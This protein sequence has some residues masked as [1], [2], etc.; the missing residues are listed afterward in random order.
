MLVEGKEIRSA[1]ELVALIEAQIASGRLRPNDRL[2]PVRAVADELGLA[3]NTV[4]AAYRTL[5][6][7]GLVNGEGRRG[8]FVA[9]RP[10]IAMP[11]DEQIPDGLIDLSS[12]NP[13][14][15]LLPDLGPALASISSRHIT[16]GESAMM[17]DLARILSDDLLADG[18]G[19]AN[20][21]VVGGALD[22][23]ERTL[24]AHVRPG[25]RVGVEDPG[26]ASVTELIAAMALRPEPMAVDEFGPRPEAVEAALAKGVSAVIVTPRAQNPTGAAIDESRAVELRR[27]F[28][29]RDVL[30]IE[31]DHAGPI[32]GQPYYSVVPESVVAE[33]GDGHWAMVRSVAKSLGPDLRLA[34]LTGDATTVGRVSGRQALGTGWVSHILQRLVANLMAADDIDGAL[35]R[36][37]QTYAA[38]R[39]ALVTTLADGGLEV[40]ARSGLNVWI[41]VTD[42][43]AVVAGMQRRGYAIRSGTRFRYN[44]PPGVRISTAG[45]E[46]ET[47]KQAGAALIE[48]IGSHQVTR[49]V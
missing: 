4:A 1:G 36:A 47:L 2:D 24:A 17:P 6:E 40:A 11:I 29:N 38:R 46:P 13:D 37:S 5:G 16:Y 44:A 25:D 10:P 30:I 22:G 12:G 15:R 43:A 45:S 3:P 27:V 34:A 35:K 18:I 26:Y 31:D 32:A 7:R 9:S 33:S 28:A 20:L 49:S 41:P 14:P 42:E 8:T 39:Q 21:C 19:A 48:T 23:I